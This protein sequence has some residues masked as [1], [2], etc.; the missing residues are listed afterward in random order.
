VNANLTSERSGSRPD[1]IRTFNEKT[2]SP[3]TGRS[4]TKA[5]IGSDASPSVMA[6]KRQVGHLVNHHGG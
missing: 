2:P 1:Q 5:V 4:K 6:Q 3:F